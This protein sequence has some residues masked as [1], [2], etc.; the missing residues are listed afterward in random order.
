MRGVLLFILLCS[1][2]ICI[3]QNNI[4]IIDSLL[5]SAMGIE[6][7]SPLKSQ[8]EAIKVISLA[9]EIDYKNGVI[10]AE[11]FLSESYIRGKDNKLALYYATE[12]DKLIATNIES[13]FLKSKALRLRGISLARLGFYDPATK[14]L[15][16]SIIYGEKIK[17]ANDRNRNLGFIYA[18]IAMNK[19]DNEINKDSVGYY[20]RKSFF[21]F[22]NID[23]ENPHKNRS[24]AFANVFLGSFY[25]K[26]GDFDK[27]EPY[28][29]NATQLSKELK[30]DFIAIESISGLG[31]INFYRGNFYNAKMYFQE[32]LL[33]AKENKRI[34]YI[35]DLYYNLSRIYSILKDQ[36]STKYYRNKYVILNDSLSKIHKDAIYTSLRFYLED[37]DEAMLTDVELIIALLSLLIIIIV[38]TFVY[39]KKYRKRFVIVK[40]ES[41]VID[42]QLKIK[43][44]LIEKIKSQNVNPKLEGT[45]LKQ[46]AIEGSPLFFAKFKEIHPEYI[47]EVIKINPTI[48]SSELKFCALIKLGFSTNEI[49][50]YTKST[51]RAVQSK[52]YRLRKK[53]NVPPEEDLY[54]WLANI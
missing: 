31:S 51:I 40:E 10:Q 27:A 42:N 22:D 39:I 48:V 24:M 14:I 35:N 16:Q 4:K 52:R 2:N 23:D 54:D 18:N 29:K 53:L 50:T 47:D 5:N 43:E 37:K 7:E 3:S 46:L 28:F 6:N 41:N 21:F 20:Y 15:K 30:L 8:L 13:S 26:K 34:F 49:A 12:A 25:L 9:K 32:A 1:Y 19:E 45:D 33:L 38:I 11:L 17:D 44:E 36:D